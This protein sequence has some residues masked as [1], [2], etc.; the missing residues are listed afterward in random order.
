MAVKLMK[1]VR[2]AVL[3]A[4]SVVA[5]A[6]TVSRAA[7]MT[8]DEYAKQTATVSYAEMARDA[9]FAQVCHLRDK[10]WS[11]VVF[12]SAR[13]IVVRSATE[14]KLASQLVTNA[15][16]QERDMLDLAYA[17]GMLA[18]L[19]MSG[20]DD[21]DDAREGFCAMISKRLKIMDS[22]YKIERVIN[23]KR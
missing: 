6:D 18:G 15:T 20:K 13:D 22:Q 4:L 19:I 7:A 14:D 16:E 10:A 17:N 11:D 21:H 9:S 2:C 1:T 23:R 8:D 3:L 5:G 12:E